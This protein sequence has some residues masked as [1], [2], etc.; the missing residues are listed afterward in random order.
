MYDKVWVPTAK[1][2]GRERIHPAFRD[3]V[4]FTLVVAGALLVVGSFLDWL[5]AWMPYRGWFTES[6]F[7]HAGDGVFTLELGL[8]ILAAT[9]SDRLTDAR[10]VFAVT[11]PFF[12]GLIAVATLRAS[13]GTLLIYLKSL[14][15]YGGHGSLIAG[16]WATVAGATL[17]TL[18]GTVRIW[19]VR[20]EVRFHVGLQFRGVIAVIG[21]VAGS[22]AGF[23][24]ATLIGGL[25]TRGSMAGVS[26]SVLILLGLA[27]ALGGAWIGAW[28][29]ARLVPPAPAGRSA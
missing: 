10:H 27:G 28:T 21:G 22:I 15:T 12:L 3:P 19:R 7:A 16:F 11:A 14:E 29:T 1:P 4:R 17:A 13:E 5:Q 2:T 23:L 8:L 24:G 25:L 18:A 9:F 20:H 26:A 6:G